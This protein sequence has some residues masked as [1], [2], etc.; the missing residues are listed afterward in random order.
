MLSGLSFRTCAHALVGRHGG[1]ENEREIVEG[2]ERVE[3]EGCGKVARW[4]GGCFV[5]HGQVHGALSREQR[6]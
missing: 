6:P 1:D 4:R 2:S 3:G 5:G